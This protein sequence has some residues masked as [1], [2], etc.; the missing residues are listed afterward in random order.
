MSPRVLRLSSHAGITA[1]PSDITVIGALSIE[2][3]LKPGGGDTRVG[4]I[5]DDRANKWHYR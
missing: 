2:A 3:K 5:S 4:T 1:V